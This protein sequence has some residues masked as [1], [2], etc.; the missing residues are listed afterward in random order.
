[1]LAYDLENVPDVRY[2]AYRDGEIMPLIAGSI[3]QAVCDQIYFLGVLIDGQP[4]PIFDG[5]MRWIFVRFH[6]G[7]IVIVT[8]ELYHIYV[9]IF[10][11]EIISR[12]QNHNNVEFV[13]P[14]RPRNGPPNG[15]VHGPRNRPVHV[16]PNGPVHGPPN[17]LVHGPPNGPANQRYRHN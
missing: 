8:P 10:P 7:Q 5:R 1:M 6:T 16:P 14:I 17:R 12:L 11:P 9:N 13:M 3:P 2:Y 4:Q 15:P